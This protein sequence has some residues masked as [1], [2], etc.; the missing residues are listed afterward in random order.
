MEIQL[1]LIGLTCV[2]TQLDGWLI[3]TTDSW[4]P[5]MGYAGMVRKSICGRT[6]GAASRDA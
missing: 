5:R 6:M 1:L 3:V 4:K 2:P